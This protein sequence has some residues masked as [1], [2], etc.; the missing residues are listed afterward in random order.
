MD[1]RGVY[2][3]SSLMKQ[4]KKAKNYAVFCFA[5]FFFLIFYVMEVI[6][7]QIF[8]QRSAN[9]YC[10]PPLGARAR[11]SDGRES[12]RAWRPADFPGPSIFTGCT[13]RCHEDVPR[14]IYGLFDALGIRYRWVLTRGPLVRALV[15]VE[16]LVIHDAKEASWMAVHE[17][18]RDLLEDTVYPR[19]VSL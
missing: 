4:N 6:V 12:S 3:F 2:R 9:H 11:R 18:E 15:T 1:I 19:L 14:H 7:K 8:Y 17:N 10:G 16:D 5:G 13:V